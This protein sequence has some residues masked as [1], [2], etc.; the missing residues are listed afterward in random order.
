MNDDLSRF[1]KAQQSDYELAL[2]EIRAG[3]KKHHWMWYIFPQLKGLGHSSTSEYY[4]I[5][6]L[7]EARAY[8]AHPVL[9]ARLD[10]ICRALLALDTDNATQVMGWPDDKKL[11]SSMTLFDAAAESSQVFR[12]V[13]DKYYRGKKDHRTLKMLGIKEYAGK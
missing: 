11:K 9:G 10:E 2:S 13:L 5:R 4:G 6:D 12:M 3:E 8:L 1:L 7:D